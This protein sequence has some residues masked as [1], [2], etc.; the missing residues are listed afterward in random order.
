MQAGRAAGRLDLR[1]LKLLDV[2]TIAFFAALVIVALVT[3]RQDVATLDKYSQALSSGA[4]GMIA[5]G[6]ILAGH[7]ST[8]DYAKE[9]A[10][11]RSRIRRSSTRSTWC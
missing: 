11:P 6:A 5:L 10:R 8:V 7:P 4:L 2:P 1:R 9:Q 3:S